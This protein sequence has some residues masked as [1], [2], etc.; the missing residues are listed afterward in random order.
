MPTPSLAFKQA[1][2]ARAP[3]ENECRGSHIVTYGMLERQKL[4]RWISDGYYCYCKL[5]NK[6]YI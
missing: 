5:L 4:G 3:A 1:E 6:F 2:V